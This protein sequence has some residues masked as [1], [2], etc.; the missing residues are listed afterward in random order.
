MTRSPSHIRLEARIAGH[1][2]RDAIVQFQAVTACGDVEQAIKYV[3]QAYGN[4]DGAVTAYFDDPE[5]EMGTPRVRR[6]P[7][8]RI[9]RRNYAVGLYFDGRR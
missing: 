7:P 8:P 9:E 3:E 1:P 2:Q 6:P 4:I 5:R